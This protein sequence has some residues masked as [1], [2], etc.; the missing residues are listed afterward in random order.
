LKTEL[1][2]G[3]VI[4]FPAQNNIAFQKKQPPIKGKG[5]SEMQFNI[6]ARSD[7]RFETKILNKDNTRKSIYGH[8]P[9]ECKEKA[10]QYMR[11]EDINKNKIT[12]KPAA[13]LTVAETLDNWYN[14]YKAPNLKPNTLRSIAAHINTVKEY[15]GGIK[16]SK[17]TAEDLQN[18]FNKIPASRTREMILEDINAVWTKA[19]INNV[20]KYNPVL[21]VSI[22][23]AEKQ[24]RS[25]FNLEQQKSILEASKNH[26]LQNI[27]LFCLITGAR[28]EE[29]CTIKPEYINEKECTLFINGTKRDSHKRTIK[30]TPAFAIWLKTLITDQ[31]YIFNFRP[32]YFTHAFK[33]IITKLK[34]KGCVHCLRHTAATNMYYGNIKDKDIQQTLG[35]KQISTTLDIYTHCSFTLKKEQIA[36]LYSGLYPFDDRF[37]DKK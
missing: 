7:G 19:L 31:P 16:F 23:K 21:A 32:D 22:R 2:H 14:L 28:R 1:E 6:T 11:G 35:H 25:P 12:I 34:I 27:I 4:T 10:L 20:I 18:M 24:K 13:S 17:V 33:D 15:I 36:D 8:S 5:E 30:I 29:A 26:K 9:K 3:N 37:D